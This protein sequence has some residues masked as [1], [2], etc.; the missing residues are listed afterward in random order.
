M[1]FR[2]PWIVYG[3]MRVSDAVTTAPAA[4]VWSMLSGLVVLYVVIAVVFIS[5]L[6]RLS[7]RWKREDTAPEEGAP[8]GPRP[9]TSPG[10]QPAG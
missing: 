4:F 2:S 1:L 9:R 10:A 6:V 8:Y 7:A 5:L 3:L